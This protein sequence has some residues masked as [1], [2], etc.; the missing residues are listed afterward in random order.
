[1][2][3]SIEFPAIASRTE[4]EWYSAQGSGEKLKIFGIQKD[5]EVDDGDDGLVHVRLLIHYLYI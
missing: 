3:K 4:V 2:A 1:M 5:S